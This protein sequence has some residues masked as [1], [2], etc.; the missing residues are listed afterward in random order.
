MMRVLLVSSLVLLAMVAGCAHGVDVIDVVPTE[1]GVPLVVDDGP[2]PDAEQAKAGVRYGRYSV[3][4]YDD[5]VVCTRAAAF[6]KTRARLVGRAWRGDHANEPG[7]LASIDAW[8][9]DTDVGHD[10]IRL[11]IS[12]ADEAADV[13]TPSTAPLWLL[14]PVETDRVPAIE[15]GTHAATQL[16]TVTTSTIHIVPVP[17]TTLAIPKL[18]RAVDLQVGD[19]LDVVVVGPPSTFA[20][21]FAWLQ[22][23]TP[24]PT[25]VPDVE[26]LR[27]LD[28]EA[29]TGVM[30]LCKTVIV[31]DF[32]FDEALVW[33]GGETR[34]LRVDGNADRQAVLDELPGILERGCRLPER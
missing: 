10:L 18:V 31:C 14:V 13:D 19:A 28:D 32:G 9:A 25:I 12:A 22:Q 11:D 8:N 6:T 20:T 34:S 1:N 16:R 33:G 23:G 21:Y 5:K 15:R 24:A 26:P 7:A 3:L 17:S 27:R 2:W 4:V 30:W 29:T